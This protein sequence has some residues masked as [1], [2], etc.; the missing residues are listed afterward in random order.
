MTYD[1][2]ENQTYD[3]TGN[4]WFDGENKMY[5]AVQGITTSHCYQL[6]VR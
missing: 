5:K 2:A 4:R 1:A 3:A 6:L